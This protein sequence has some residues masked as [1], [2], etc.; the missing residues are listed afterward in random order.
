MALSDAEETWARLDDHLRARLREDLYGRWFRALRAVGLEG[1][2]LAVAAPDKF[3]RDF[4]DDNYRHW[5]DDEVIPG[6][7]GLPLRIQFVVDDAPRAPSQ[8]SPGGAVAIAPPPAISAATEADAFSRDARPN[9]RY[10]FDTFV[11]GESN[12]FAVAAAQ[13][14]AAKP[15]RTWNP[16]FLHGMSGLGKTHLLHAIAH[17]IPL[18]T[19]GARVAIV[20]S[21]RYTNDFVDALS[22]G[23]MAD[24]RKKYRECGALLV[25]DVQFFAGREKTAE[26]FFHTFNALYEQN[27][28]IVLSSDRSPKEL[29]GLEE[30]LC[31]RF[32]WGMRVQIDAPE[33]ET[34]A[35]I[36]KK[37]AEVEGIELPDPVSELLAT[38]IRSNVRELEG[39]LMRLAAF[40]SLKSEKITDAL[41]RDV[42][43]DHIPPPGYKPSIEK[44]QEAVALKSGITVPKLTSPSREQKIALP[45]QIAM[46]LCRELAKET[47]QSIAEKFNKKDHTTVIAAVQK[48]A[49]LYEND[50]KVRASIDEL[51]THLG[52]A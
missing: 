32:G 25:D 33:F 41:A 14:V 20:S 46:F 22:K 6:V 13:S 17:A 7:L 50:A 29:K 51:R 23:T 24:F 31:S 9:P 27:I 48:V 26:E 34:R 16:L 18:A 10:T 5:F 45:R 36:L 42:L 11:V 19:P 38:H 12:R 3:H 4:V 44:I 35:A 40:A 39:A 21:E 15:G 49:E 43:S 8:A 52:G 37:K 28:Q 1:E 30:R 47:Y 2:R